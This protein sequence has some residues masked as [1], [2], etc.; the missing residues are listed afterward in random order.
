MFGPRIDGEA[1]WAWLTYALPAD[2]RL[3]MIYIFLAGQRW[4]R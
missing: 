1:T 3:L 4:V 2:L